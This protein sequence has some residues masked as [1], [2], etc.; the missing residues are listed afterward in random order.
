MSHGLGRHCQS[1]AIQLIQQV[2]S[3]QEQ[4]NVYGI[5]TSFE[6][7]HK[8]LRHGLLERFHYLTPSETPPPTKTERQPHEMYRSIRV[9]V[10]VNVRE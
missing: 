1:I 8:T 7:L 3:K 9:I 6:H 4:E 5:T 10:G 2:C